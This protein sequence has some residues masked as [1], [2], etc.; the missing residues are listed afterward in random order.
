MERDYSMNAGRLAG[1]L[2]GGKRDIFKKKLFLFHLLGKQIPA[3][4]FQDIHANLF[5]TVSKHI[6][7]NYFGLSRLRLFSSLG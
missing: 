1:R 5:V 6:R 2:A 3:G 7:D 4:S